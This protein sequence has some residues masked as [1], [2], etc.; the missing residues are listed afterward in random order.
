MKCSFCEHELTVEMLR[1]K[2][3]GACIGGCRKI[4]CP[5]CGQ[6]INDEIPKTNNCQEIHPAKIKTGYPFC[7]NCGKAL[8]KGIKN[9]KT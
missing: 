1:E 6:L 3:C 7:N 5:F 2:G 9:E 8:Q 4:H